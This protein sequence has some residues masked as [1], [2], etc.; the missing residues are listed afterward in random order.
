M[1]LRTGPSLATLAL[2]GGAVLALHLGVLSHPASL[3]RHAPPSTPAPLPAQAQA[4][5][6][7][8]QMTQVRTVTLAPPATPVQPT[9][10]PPRATM[11]PARSG[12][13][14][15]APPSLPAPGTID[16]V[17]PGKDSLPAPTEAQTPPPE[18]GSAGS[19]ESAALQ[20]LAQATTP[21]PSAQDSPPPS[22]PGDGPVLPPSDPPPSIT[23]PYDVVGEAGG[24]SYRASGQLDWRLDAQG[25]EARMEL[26]MLFLGS[27]VQTSR[28][29]VGPE[30]LRP[31]RFADRRR[32]ERAAHFDRESG[33]IRFS[34]NA[35]P[36]ELMPGAQDRLSL[37]MQL[38]GLLRARTHREGEVIAFQVAG[39][40]DAEPWHFEVGPVETLDLPSGPLQARR[41][42]RTPRKP[43]DSTV[44]VWLA[45]SLGH[46]PVRLRV[47]QANGDV[48][49]QRLAR[50]P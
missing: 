20:T 8:L 34:N 21:A 1:T 18:D 49:D 4:A 3:T 37:F 10:A 42:A 40:G 9:P 50:L 15:A 26:S 17:Q 39:I 36:A 23:L 12:A 35:A 31:E 43:H 30:G 2:L 22:L 32:S 5:P 7:A 25:Y 48:A 44:E 19:N 11:A 14:S 29:S 24:L 27:R 38:A 13:T 47:A 33:R 45:P 46:L 28:G 16:T 41:L 6:P